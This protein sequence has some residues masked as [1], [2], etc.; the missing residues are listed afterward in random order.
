MKK[1]I[2]VILS[3]SFTLLIFSCGSTKEV[4]SAA[5]QA[6]K[7]GVPTW[8]YEGRRDSKGIYATVA[9]K[10]SNLTNSLK[11]ARAQARLELANTVKIGVEGV[12]QTLVDDQGSDKDRQNL[13]ALTEHALF[14]TDT[15]L[16]GS[17][18]V[19]YF[20]D[21]DGTVYVLMFLPYSTM[22]TELNKNLETSK[23]FVRDSTAAYTE[24]KMAEA[25]E[26]F[27]ADNK[28]N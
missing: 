9:G 8:V 7:D 13:E 27:F 3:L 1:I 2:S 18:Q 4:T 15:I 22:V 10:L 28:S 12:T 25:Y 26:K 6:E 24:E 19:D 17:E 5:I 11:M 14:K 16:Q 23:S 21:K 20:Q